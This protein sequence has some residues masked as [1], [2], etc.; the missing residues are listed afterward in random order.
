LNFSAAAQKKSGDQRRNLHVPQCY[1]TEETWCPEIIIMQ[2][3]DNTHNLIA[4][5]SRRLSLSILIV[6]LMLTSLWYRITHY[7]IYLHKYFDKMSVSPFNILSTCVWFQTR[8]KIRCFN[9]NIILWNESPY[10]GVNYWYNNWRHVFRI[11]SP[12]RLRIN[13]FLFA[14]RQHLHCASLAI[15]RLV[16]MFGYWWACLVGLRQRTVL[17]T[18]FIWTTAIGYHSFGEGHIDNHRQFTPA[19]THYIGGCGLWARWTQTQN[20]P[21]PLLSLKIFFPL[22]LIHKIVH[23]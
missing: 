7:L 2:F 23:S 9:H 15:S 5:D 3:W 21:I 16:K 13:L 4:N 1:N 20:S 17:F 22:L 11:T 6:L 19:W 14:R 18:K 10:I 12:F 8:T